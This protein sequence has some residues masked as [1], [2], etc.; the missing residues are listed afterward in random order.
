MSPTK[1]RRPA[2]PNFRTDLVR[3]AAAIGIAAEHLDRALV[4]GQIAGLLAQ[5][6]ALKGNIAHK[7]AAM[8]HLVNRSK[9]FSRDLDSA[10]IRGRA[11]DE[12]AIRRAL[13]TPAARRVV[14]S[15][16]KITSRG[17]DSFTLLL[18]CRPL[19]GGSS[20]GITLSINWSEPFLRSPVVETYR[21]RGDEAIAVPVM[22]P[23]E[24]AA[25]K[26][27]A[28]LTRGEAADAYDL[29]WY[30][31]EVLTEAEILGLRSLIKQKLATSRLAD[32]LE[33]HAR[34]DEMEASARD[35]W[36]KGH[37]LIIA[38]TDRPPWPSVA[39]VLA[40]FRRVVPRRPR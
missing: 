9:R 10:D 5:D 19:H 11:V 20:I 7:G 1:H 17:E 4:I 18:N 28:F 25:E 37:G 26:V 24:R 31:S 8:L 6:K 32:D 14:L 2:G 27:R 21:V 33:L 15:I 13:S 36:E 22:D 16:A 39:A 30:G 38:P 23:R 35:E 3:R 29:W 12:R 40:R 34:F